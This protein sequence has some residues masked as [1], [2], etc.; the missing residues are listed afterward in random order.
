MLKN[1]QA[2]DL[3]SLA[4]Y[5]G[6]SEAIRHAI[7]TSGKPIPPASMIQFTPAVCCSN[8]KLG[9]DVISRYLKT[10]ATSNIRESPVVSIIARLL[11]MQVNNAAVFY[12]L[13]R[14]RKEKL[15]PNVDEVEE[16][17]S[18]G[19]A[20]IRHN[21]TQCFTLGAFARTLAKEWVE[22]YGGNGEEKN[23][24]SPEHASDSDKI[25]QCF[26][27]ML[28]SATTGPRNARRFNRKHNRK[29][30]TGPST[31]FVLRN[32]SLRG[33]KDGKTKLKRKGSLQTQWCQTCKRAISTV[34][35]QGWN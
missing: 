35:W 12:R 20:A 27:D 16:S 11:C 4:S 8:H 24:S 29:N 17:Y 33:N 14:A 34:C 18:R 23:N 5:Y 3:Y 9:V 31:Y 7:S 6:L 26:D 15:L 32:W 28:L 22:R 2:S 10:L 13:N 25:T 19:Y 30:V 21:V 1:S